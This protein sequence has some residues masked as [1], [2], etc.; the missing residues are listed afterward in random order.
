MEELVTLVRAAQDGDLAAYGDILR[1]FQHMVYGCAYAV[2]GDFH[3]AEDGQ[4][5]GI[6]LRRDSAQG[7][8]RQAIGRWLRAA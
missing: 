1:R 2:L 7:K 4:S 8:A 6:G 5:G 3:L